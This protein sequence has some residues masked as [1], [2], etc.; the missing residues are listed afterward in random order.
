M[1]VPDLI[2]ERIIQILGKVLLHSIWEIGLAAFILLIVLTILR[3]HSA[4]LKYNFSLSI[5]FISLLGLAYTFLLISRDGRGIDDVGLDRVSAEE[6][7]LDISSDRNPDNNTLETR[8]MVRHHIQSLFQL[9]ERN[10]N[11]IV[12]IWFTGIFLFSLRTT[13][14]LVIISR[15]KR[16]GTTVPLNKWISRFVDLS[17]KINIHRKIKVLIS[18]RVK[19]PMVIGFI[20]PVILV[21][22]SIITHLPVEQ[23]DAIIAHELAHIK[24]N[25]Y[26]INLIQALFS[27]SISSISFIAL[28]ISSIIAF[29]SAFI[30]AYSSFVIFKVSSW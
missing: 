11:L 12:F 24:R 9:Y 30:S 13:G 26:L 3:N 2:P 10:T 16:S 5:L 15:L 18:T 4:R 19:T 17:G 28:F 1:I 27:I 14:G 29:N 6:I 7:T 25:D 21:P 20:K 23:V 22:I 8:T